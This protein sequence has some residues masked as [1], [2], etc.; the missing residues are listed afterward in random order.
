MAVAVGLPACDQAPPQPPAS[1]TAPVA[2]GYSA[3]PISFNDDAQNNTTVDPNNLDLHFVDIKGNQVT[4]QDFHE[5][6]N[7]VLVFTRGFS[8]QI[9]PFCTTQTSRL[10]AN[11]QEF[12]KRDTEVLAV[13]PGDKSSVPAFLKAVE[14]QSKT[15]PGEP[16]F[17]LLLDEQ[18]AAVDRLGIRGDLAKPSTYILDKQGQVR[19]AYVGAHAAD[20]PSIKALLNQLDILVSE[21]PPPSA[22]AP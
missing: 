5:K 2:Y 13:Y 1:P 17:P 11:Y 10:A 9:C 20:R 15:G 7:I 12:A 19:F 21:Q 14:A 4:L 6:K 3:A 22:P 18:M 8:G 16:P